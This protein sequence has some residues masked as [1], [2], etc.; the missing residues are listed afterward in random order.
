VKVFAKNS[1]ESNPSPLWE[2][3]YQLMSFAGK[4]VK[5]EIEKRGKM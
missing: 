3:K 4:N 2:E 1:L 5:M